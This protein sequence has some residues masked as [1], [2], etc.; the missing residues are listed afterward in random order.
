[1]TLPD[2]YEGKFE[3]VLT[4][5]GTIGRNASTVVIV[6]ESDEGVDDI[7]VV[8]TSKRHPG[9]VFNTEIGGSLAVADALERLADFYRSGISF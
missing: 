1:M 4:V 5:E 3:V 9:E 8:G 2:R 7:T 6:A